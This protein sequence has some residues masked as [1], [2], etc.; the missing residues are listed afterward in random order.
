MIKLSDYQQRLKEI[1]KGQDNAIDTITTTIYKYLMKLY[2]R[3]QGI[4]FEGAS[5][6][7]LVGDSGVGKTYL[8][9]QAA[10][11]SGLSMMEINAKSICQEGWHGKSFLEMVKNQTSNWKYDGGIIFIDEIDKL[12]MKNESSNNDDVNYHIQA[13]LLKYI[14]GMQTDWIDFNKCLFVFAGAFVGLDI[15]KEPQKEI[16][17]H[18]PIAEEKKHLNEALTKFGMLEELAGRIQEKVILNKIDTR[19]FRDLL[20]TETFCL[21]QWTETLKKMDISLLVDYTS[22]IEEAQKSNLGVRGLIQAV[23]AE[24]TRAINQELH[25]VDLEKYSPLYCPPTNQELKP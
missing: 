21:T 19:V 14:E 10:K 22:L 7:L 17:F 6:L 25:K 11:L 18:T 16:G 3:D 8:I 4:Y 15:G 20:Q 5:S 13:G 1:V 2:S 24:V 23:E 9:K 12:C